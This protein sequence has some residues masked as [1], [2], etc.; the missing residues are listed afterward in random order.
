MMRRLR[1]KLIRAA[2]APPRDPHE[3]YLVKDENPFKRGRTKEFGYVCTCWR[4]AAEVC[5]GCVWKKKEE[6]KLRKRRWQPS[7][8][9]VAMMERSKEINRREDKRSERKL[10][11]QILE[12]RWTA[13][14]ESR[15]EEIWSQRYWIIKAD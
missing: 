14:R 13:R 5:K 2:F 7:E 15:R 8:R 11:N 6:K 9:T 3:S 12:E 10:A 4:G 1:N